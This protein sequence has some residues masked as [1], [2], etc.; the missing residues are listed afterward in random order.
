M[1]RQRLVQLLS[2]ITIACLLTF[3]ASAD[4]YTLHEW[5]TFTSVIGSDGSHLNGVQRED[6][7]LPEFVY[8][9]DPQNAHS[10]V[11]ALRREIRP[12][13]IQLT[14]GID[15]RRSFVGVNVRLETPVI[16]FY[17]D[18]PFDAEVEV[19]FQG[20]T[21]SQWY[22][23]RSAGEKR[24]K[25]GR[26]DFRQPRSGSIR[27]NV[28]VEPAGD[29][30]AERVFHGGELPCWLYPRYPDSALVTNA[31]GETEK[32]LFYRG[33]GHLTLPVQ[34]SAS[35][36][37]LTAGNRGTDE[38]RWLLF[39]L[40]EAGQARWSVPPP[41]TGTVDGNLAKVSVPFHAQPWRSDWK[42]PLYA[43]GLKLLTD[44]GLYRSEADAMLQTWW[45][46]YFETPGV[47]V[48]WVV[49]RAMVDDIL[50]LRV[51]P[52]PAAVERVIV[53]RSEILT[54]TFEQRLVRDFVA[55]EESGRANPWTD[56]RFFPAYASR[57]RRLRSTQ[58]PSTSL[59]GNTPAIHESWNNCIS[60]ARL[61]PNIR[62]IAYE[63][64]NFGGRKLVLDGAA[65][66]EG[67]GTYPL[68]LGRHDELAKNETWNDRI[69]SLKIVT[70][71]ATETDATEIADQDVEFFR[72][73]N[74]GASS[75]TLGAGTEIPDLTNHK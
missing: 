55:A 24:F 37:E 15:L 39:D 22:P 9:L 38:I 8:H 62:V 5:G 61:G 13:Q 46:S 44:A 28:H 25:P 54:P 74:F 16:Y 6:A 49:P 71:G 66:G 73:S 45:K 3:G 47:R 2:T 21:I 4:D 48:F 60:S 32:Y 56:D 63:E 17:T 68:L 65:A 10:A 18:R 7:P 52:P 14:K 23:N 29:D 26:L 40:N 58:R 34:F 41:L 33:L 67:N 51:T 11:A 75:L 36:S 1:H 20:G 69:S 27:W 35:E 43:D 42:R 57:V 30:Q 64:A 72:D 53:G 50:P 12:R 70:V 31:D 59:A 19:G